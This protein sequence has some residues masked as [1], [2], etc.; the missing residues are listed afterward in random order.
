[1]LYFYFC[2]NF[3]DTKLNVH[4]QF[5]FWTAS[6]V[7]TVKNATHASLWRFG[8]FWTVIELL[9]I[10]GGNHTLLYTPVRE[11]R[12]VSEEF[13]CLCIEEIKCGKLLFNHSWL[14]DGKQ[15]STV[16]IKI[17]GGAYFLQTFLLRFYQDLGTAMLRGLSNYQ[18]LPFHAAQQHCRVSIPC[19]GIDLCEKL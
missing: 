8:S 19:S 15:T 16:Q 17:I 10:V 14:T 9:V 11:G 2:R 6:Q 1:M 4:K 18:F 13:C 3:I 5:R 7:E 12:S